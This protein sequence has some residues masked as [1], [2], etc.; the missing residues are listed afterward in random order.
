MCSLEYSCQR[1]RK[2]NAPR[3]QIAWVMGREPPFLRCLDLHPGD[4]LPGSCFPGQ[5]IHSIFLPLNGLSEYVRN[6]FGFSDG[7]G[8][9]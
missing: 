4:R 5:T 9:E 8:K 2:S 6:R 1:H 3:E 7:F